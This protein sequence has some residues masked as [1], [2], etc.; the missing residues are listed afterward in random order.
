MCVRAR[1]RACTSKKNLSKN[2][3]LF[4]SLYVSSGPRQKFHDLACRHCQ[5]KTRDILYQRTQKV[6]YRN[7]DILTLSRLLRFPFHE[8]PYEAPDTFPLSACYAARH[9]ELTCSRRGTYRGEGVATEQVPSRSETHTAEQAQTNKI[10]YGDNSLRLVCVCAPRRPQPSTMSLVATGDRSR[11]RHDVCL[12][13]AGFNFSRELEQVIDA[14]S[15]LQEYEALM[16]DQFQQRRRELESEAVL[17]PR[18]L[19]PR[20]LGKAWSGGQVHGT[21]PQWERNE[22]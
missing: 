6:Q 1:A 3:V 19:A 14:D 21:G 4:T 12:G 17:R 5:N 9:L 22:A 8:P 16:Q 10:K 13:D 18:H 15:R 7:G 11:S 20:T 2:L